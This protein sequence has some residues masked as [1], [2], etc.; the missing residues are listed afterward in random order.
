MPRLLLLWFTLL[1]SLQAASLEDAVKSVARGLTA[2]LAAGETVQITARNLTALPAQELEKARALL[3]RAMRR[4]PARNKPPFDLHLHLS[5]SAAGFL[6]IA[7]LR[8]GPQRFVEMAP[9]DAAPAAVSQRPVL[10]R[11]IIRQQSTPLLDVAVFE[12]RMLVLS[13]RN[14]TLHEQR[15]GKWELLASKPLATPPTR[16][17][18]GSLEVT[19]PTF[20]AAISGAS[21]EGILQPEL[22]IT[23]SS[24]PLSPPDDAVPLSSGLTLKATSDGR[25]QV[26]NTQQTVVSSHEGWGSAIAASPETCGAKSLVF[27]TAQGDW[28]SPDTLSL[29]DWSTGKP[30]EAGNRL[31]FPAPIT[32]LKPYPGGTLAITANHAEESYSAYLVTVD[33]S[34]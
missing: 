4:A 27:H 6:L 33:C 12:N 15:D 32:E 10:T 7:E 5:E 25:L 22:D 34:R 2:R 17:P 14:V 16:D 20:R 29:H 18:R 13:A 24:S 26:L 31:E 28:Y 3:Q 23:C 9:F 19:P 11:R 1:T 30:I 8:H 21:C